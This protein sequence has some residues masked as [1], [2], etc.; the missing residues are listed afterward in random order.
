MVKGQSTGSNFS[1][2]TNQGKTAE[3]DSI[4]LGGFSRL[5]FVAASLENQ[6]YIISCVISS[7]STNVQLYVD[8]FIG[9]KQEGGNWIGVNLGERSV[10]GR[11][12]G[13]GGTSAFGLMPFTK[14][15]NVGES[16]D[17]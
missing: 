8:C 3:I 17:R 2:R 12:G 5:P 11:K 15:L 16:T 6:M 1:A 9:G 13:G 10:L 14:R 7:G 4:G